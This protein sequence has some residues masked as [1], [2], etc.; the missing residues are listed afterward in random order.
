MSIGRGQVLLL[1]GLS[2]ALYA[3]AAGTNPAV[4]MADPAGLVAG[5]W[6]GVWHGL[7]VPI[8]FVV[9]LFSDQVIIYEV[10]NNGAWYNF[11]FL[12]GVHT[13][14]AGQE[15]RRRVVKPKPGI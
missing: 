3:C 12:I 13:I 9:S 11:G 1:F 2:L 5:F 15:T 6:R 7:I 4:N 14:F 10:H 8:S